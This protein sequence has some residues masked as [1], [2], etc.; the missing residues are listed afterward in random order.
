MSM[1]YPKYHKDDLSQELCE[2]NMWLLVN[3]QAVCIETSTF[4][5]WTITNQR[6]AIYKMTPLTVQCQLQSTVWLLPESMQTI[7]I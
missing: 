7:D 1:V 4:Y 3:Q 6:V 5:E 2:P